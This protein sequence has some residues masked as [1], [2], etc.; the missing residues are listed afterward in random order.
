MNQTHD[1]LSATRKRLAGGRWTQGH[2]ARSQNNHPTEYQSLEA[3][4]WCIAGALNLEA[5]RL[6]GCDSDAPLVAA[7]KAIKDQ[8]L[9][10]GFVPEAGQG[11]VGWNDAGDRTEA[12]VLATLDRAIEACKEEM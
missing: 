7:E 4:K 12:D 1:L 10:D 5:L 6:Y 2:F 8:V 3:V 11:L 9:Q